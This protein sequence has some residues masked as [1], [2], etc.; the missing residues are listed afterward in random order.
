MN[1]KRKYLP[2]IHN[3]FP[4]LLAKLSKEYN[5]KNFIH[6]SALGI[7]QAVESE[8]ARSKLEGENNILKSALK[9]LF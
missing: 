8:Y 7:N 6:L 5:L 4:T 2:N 9:P 1:K 3:V